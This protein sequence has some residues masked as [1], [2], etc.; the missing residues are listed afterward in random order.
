MTTPKTSS[1]RAV[2]RVRAELAPV[3]ARAHAALDTLDIDQAI[4]AG[5]QL[6]SLLWRAEH[7]GIDR[8]RLLP[9]A[10]PP[11]DANDRS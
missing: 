3:L 1:E 4:A 11:T 2:E 5:R 6:R 10:T 9:D 8:A 7:A